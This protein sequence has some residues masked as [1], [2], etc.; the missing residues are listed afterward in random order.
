MRRFLKAMEGERS[1][2]ATGTGVFG[3]SAL[4]YVERLVQGQVPCVLIACTVRGEA[5]FEQFLDLLDGSSDLQYKDVT[6][7]GRACFSDSE[8]LYYYP[9][10]RGQ[11]KIL[12][13][14]SA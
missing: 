12:C 4:Q 11:I 2:T 3:E 14:H 9:E 13:I 10:D 5:T 8:P 7:W 1:V 6:D